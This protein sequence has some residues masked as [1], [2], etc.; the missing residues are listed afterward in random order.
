M[1]KLFGFSRQERLKS[2]KDIKRLFEESEHVKAFPIRC[3]FLQNEQSTE[4]IGAQA[5]FSVP[6]RS[7]KKAAHR[8]R[9]KRRMKEAYRLHKSIL[10]DASK[11]N[12]TSYQLMFIYINREE[13][14]FDKIEKAMK[15][16]LAKIAEQTNSP[17]S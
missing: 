9:I 7:F 14:P 13:W 4:D 2:R 5:A 15:K 6:K 8:N 12:N 10:L 11:K 3:L 17:S 1:R 16:S